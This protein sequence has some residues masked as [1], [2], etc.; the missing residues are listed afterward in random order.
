MS[1][2]KQIVAVVSLALL[3]LVPVARAG[4]ATLEGIVND[5]SGHALQGA[6]IRIQG[7][8]PKV[9]IVHTDASGRYAY[10]ALETGAYQVS[11]VVNGVMKAS[12]KNV[13]TQ[14]GRT[15]TLN[16]DI[17]RG[18]A[19]PFANGKHYVWVPASEL[20]GTH[21]GAWIELDDNAKAMP[22][23]MQERIRNQGNQQ[24]KTLQSNS[25]TMPN[26]M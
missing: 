12:I 2:I 17:H 6:E 14:V 23:G 20:T 24:V 16:F 1:S 11:L 3:F 9:G 4:V 22:S 26:Q 21:I 18:A 8:G 5:A 15:E 7:T 19:K 13:K 10:P 25:A